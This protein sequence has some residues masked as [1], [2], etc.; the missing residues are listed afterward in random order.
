[1]NCYVYFKNKEA[2]YTTNQFK[3]V[4][5]DFGIHY[6]NKQNPEHLLNTLKEYHKVEINGLVAYCGITLEWHYK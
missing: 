4:I 5:D 6:V 2:T 1:M 3:F